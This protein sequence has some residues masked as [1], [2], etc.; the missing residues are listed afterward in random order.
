MVWSRFKHGLILLF[1]LFLSLLAVA[2][3]LAF[4]I[5]L[6]LTFAVALPL[7]ALL[8]LPLPFL[9]FCLYFYRY[10]PPWLCRCRCR[11]L[12]LLCL[13]RWYCCYF[14]RCL[15]L[16]FSVALPLASTFTVTFAPPFDL[17]Y[18]SDLIAH[19][20]QIYDVDHV[21]FTLRF[22]AKIS[23]R[24]LVCANSTMSFLLKL[25][26]VELQMTC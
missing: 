16:A 19:S 1:L 8:T 20:A 6:P 17:A 12:S 18:I 4:A 22:G 26:W 5:A 13:C 2:V 10:H 24:G 7:L 3:I 11:C 15:A 9:C 14:Y 23:F 21:L 25:Y